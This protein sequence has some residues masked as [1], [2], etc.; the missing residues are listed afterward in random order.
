MKSQMESSK[1]GSHATPESTMR[2]DETGL[3]TGLLRAWG[4]GDFRARDDL[5]PLVYAEL[6]RRAA[7]Y[8]RHERIRHRSG[9]EP[10]VDGDGDCETSGQAYG[11]FAVNSLHAVMPVHRAEPLHTNE[12]RIAP[13]APETWERLR[14]HPQF[15]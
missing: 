1:Q 3:V 13:L 9:C 12:Y 2:P 7:L 5:M 8:L 6:R 4:Q 10:D 11:E 15:Q 14:A